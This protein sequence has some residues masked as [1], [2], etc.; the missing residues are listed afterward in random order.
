MPTKNPRIQI[1]ADEALT[2][3]LESTRAVLPAGLSRAGR[4]HALALAGARTLSGSDR[5]D[6]ERLETLRRLAD[7][8][9]DA[10]DR[11]VLLNARQTAWRDPDR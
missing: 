1:T 3:A 2:A 5:D 8:V 10:V 4:V 11:D 6:R 9:H 7:S